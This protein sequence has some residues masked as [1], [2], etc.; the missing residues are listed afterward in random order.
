MKKKKKLRQG[1]P[2]SWVCLL[3][4][5]A[6]LTPLAATEETGILLENLV[7]QIDSQLENLE[8]S[9]DA[10]GREQVSIQESLRELKAE[11]ESADTEP[12]RLE[13]KGRIVSELSALNLGD[14]RLVEQSMAAMLNVNRNLKQLERVFADGIMSEQVIEERREHIRSALQNLAPVVKTLSESIQDPLARQQ[15]RASQQ[16]LVLLYRQ[17]ESTGTVDGKGVLAQIRGTTHAIEDVVAQLAVVDDLLEMER[18]QLRVVSEISIGEL[19]FARL[20]E[21]QFEGRSLFEVPLAFQEG[22]TERN[23]LFG[24]ILDTSLKPTPGNGLQEDEAA[25]LERIFAG[26]LPK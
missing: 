20:S 12:E 16:M 10:L 4:L 26:E 25:L 22:V 5:T 1:R 24:S 8:E 14:R 21:V 23:R 19:L 11:Y 7:A 2:L 9:V 3:L 18:Y 17:L 15:A 6:G 13:V